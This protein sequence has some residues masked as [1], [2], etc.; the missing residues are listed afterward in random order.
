MVDYNILANAEAPSLMVK[1]T[2]IVDRIDVVNLFPKKQPIDLELGTGDGTFLVEYAK[3]HP[4]RNFLGVER[5]LGRA[6]KVEKKALRAGLEN[7]RVIRIEA[8]Y[9]VRYLLPPGCIRVVHIYFP[10]PWP[11]AR[12]AKNR[13]IQP[14]FVNSLAQILE[15]NGE[16]FLRTDSPD[17]F[18]QMLEVFG[19]SKNFIKIETPEELKQMHTDF[20][21][22]FM[23]QGVNTLYV[24]YRF[25]G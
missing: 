9:F 1:L 6:R 13:L 19:G 17:Y 23:A 7:V 21:K 18:K 22:E 2:S 25:C 10:D 8:S 5:L 4:E 12:H 3:L 15:P 14:E 24:A 20:E 11:K 16:V